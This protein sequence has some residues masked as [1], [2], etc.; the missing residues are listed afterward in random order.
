MLDGADGVGDGLTLE[1][2][3][4]AGEGLTDGDG[5]TIGEGE[6]E[7]ETEGEADGPEDCTEDGPVEGIGETLDKGFV[8]AEDDGSIEGACSGVGTGSGVN[9]CVGD[10]SVSKEPDVVTRETFRF[11]V[12]L[13]AAEGPL[14][15]GM[16]LQPL[17]TANSST[18][19][20][21]RCLNGITEVPQL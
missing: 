4:A 3:D 19:L 15:M 16:P 12:L 6:T 13:G 14:R 7:G 17:L 5:V 9:D 21:A 1:L 2:E 8:E 18:I 10:G 11:T 20:I